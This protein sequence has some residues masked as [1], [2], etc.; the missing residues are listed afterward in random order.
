MA[1]RKGA[2]SKLVIKIAA[3]M[4][5]AGRATYKQRTF[6]NVN[7]ALT[8]EDFLSIGNKLAALQSEEVGGIVRQ[9]AASIIAG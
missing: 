2:T 7:P 5:A 1:T 6:T 9:D 3:G 4:N 8:D